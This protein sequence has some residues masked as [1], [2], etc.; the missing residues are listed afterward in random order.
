MS[1]EST[2]EMDS[3]QINEYYFINKNLESKN[4]ITIRPLRCQRIP[5]KGELILSSESPYILRS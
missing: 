3:P 2:F 4:L 5:T 1:I